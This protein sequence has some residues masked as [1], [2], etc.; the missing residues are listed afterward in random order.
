MNLVLLVLLTQPLRYVGAQPQQST[1]R[2]FP[3]TGHWVQGVFLK[4][5]NSHGGLG[6]Q[7]YPLTEEFRETN[8]LNGQTY[9]VQYFERAIFEYHPEY[10]P[11][12]DVLL[13]PLGTFELDARYPNKSNPAA[14]ARPSPTPTI[15]PRPTATPTRTATPLPSPTP[16]APVMS[17][18]ACQNAPQLRN[19]KSFLCMKSEQGDYIGQGEFT[20]I[21]PS[22]GAFSG[23]P[24]Y[25]SGVNITVQTE[26]WWH[27]DFG[28]PENTPFYPGRYLDAQRFAFHAPPKP[29]MDVSGA[30]RGCNELSGKFEFLAIVIDEA[31]K[32]LKRFAANFEQHCEK[33][34]PPLYGEIRFNSDVAP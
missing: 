7:G 34:M 18:A 32:E 30:G 15:T 4:Y 21:T 14:A 23:R 33:F 3:E 16:Q 27:L 22:E 6:Q 5:W 25:R 20:I 10:Q 9:T 8:K 24:E 26:D 13:S 19:L 1:S 28:P 11:P 12:Y 17:V 2:Y 31:A 29:G